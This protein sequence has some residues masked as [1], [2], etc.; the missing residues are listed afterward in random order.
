MGR[1]TLAVPSG[2]ILGLLRPNGARKSTAV[3]LLTTLLES[4]VW[5]VLVAGYDIMQ[6]HQEVPNQVN[7]LL[8]VMLPGIP[9]TFVIGF[10]VI[11]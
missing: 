8:A 9:A 7:A 3:K 1:L 10:D 5:T 4:T 11:A 2:T 6:D